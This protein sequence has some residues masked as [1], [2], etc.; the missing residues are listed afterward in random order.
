M[1]TSQLEENKRKLLLLNDDLEKAFGFD[2]LELFKQMNK[3]FKSRLTGKYWK[4]L[5]LTFK[6]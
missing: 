5:E 1:V 2:S 4:K 3:G 6:F